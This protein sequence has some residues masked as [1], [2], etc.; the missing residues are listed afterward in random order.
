[1]E[2][3]NQQPAQT[4]SALMS[5]AAILPQKRKA[6]PAE[7]ELSPGTF[8]MTDNQSVSVGTVDSQLPKGEYE[9]GRVICEA[10]GEGISFRDEITGGFTVK[11]WDEH[12]LQCPNISQQVQDATAPSPETQV[13]ASQ[14]P[15]KRRRAKRSEEER[16]DYLRSDPY[17]AQFEAY[18]VL[19]ASCDKWI[20]LRPNSTYCSIPWD[21]H[22]KS[23]LAKKFAKNASPTDDRSNV[24]VTDPLV[25]KFDAERVLCR[26]CET[27]IR[28]GAHDNLLAVK[29]WMEHRAV[30]QQEITSTSAAPP[31]AA[32]IPTIDSVPPPPKHLL[33]LAS[34]SSLPPPV[35]AGPPSPTVNPIAVQPM[36]N[37]VAT[38]PQPS[39][40]AFKDLNPLN[41]GPAHESRRRNAEQRAAALRSDPL[42][43]DVEPNRVFCTLCQKWVQ[44]RQD[45]SYCAYPW[46]QHRG[47]CL[48]R[49][50][51][52]AQKDV[53]LAAFRAQRT[54]SVTA[55]PS[56]GADDSDGPESEEGVESGTE[57]EK[58]RRRAE[59][60]EARK[61]A[62]AEAL[63]QLR[64]ED[65][66][67]QGGVGVSMFDI[68][69]YDDDADG[70]YDMDP[71]VL[72]PRYT[73]LDSPS[74]RFDFIFGSVK[75]LF[76]STFDQNDE[77]TIA[78]L[79]TYLNAAM[80][81]DKHEDYDTAEVIK[82]AMAL[83]ERG[84]FI[85]Q[86]DVLRVPN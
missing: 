75:H 58:G 80:P 60:R 61:K 49:H 41:F 53:E 24:F 14:P 68:S 66:E 57:E 35:P 54:L 44:L 46:L 26:N 83:H 73:D 62:K 55:T 9:T 27:W 31:S 52:R 50:Q 85:F 17:V 10:C 65:E 77:L 1:M 16:I 38:V 23:C 42:V 40:S 11:H 29:K 18:R 30:C 32:N 4:L 36:S 69:G 76:K 21:A 34:S 43:G 86:G 78:A 51:K 33:A 71:D 5:S 67:K 64:Q 25:R 74:G 82:G 8:G 59:R 63:T 70:D 22:R 45:S 47:K 2:I 13:D 6:P 28:L 37:G 39:P 56:V 7:G 81:P 15:A 20:R 48:N 3:E 72:R 12:R 84:D 19:C 79:V